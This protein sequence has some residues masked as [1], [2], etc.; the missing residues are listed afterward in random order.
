MGV[1][2]SAAPAPPE[3][4]RAQL[5]EELLAH[6]IELEMQ[7]E[8]LR[9]SQD[10]LR[11]EHD[12]YLDLYDLAPVGYLV[13]DD[14]GR[15]VEAN[16]R[17]AEVFGMS[18]ADLKEQP[19]GCLVADDDQDRLFLAQ[20]KVRAT[21]DRC[22]LEVRLQRRDPGGA[23]WVRCECVRTDAGAHPGALRV[24]LNDITE[25][26]RLQVQLALADRLA[27]LGALVASIGHEINNPLTYVLYDLET[28]TEEL[29]RV[30][31][32][33]RLAAGA[34][35]AP[36]SPPNG[37]V[38]VGLAELIERAQSALEGARRIRDLVKGVGAFSS[39]TDGRMAAVSLN[40]VLESTLVLI[41]RE[42]GLR[43]RL[44]TDLGDIPVVM[45]DPRQLCQVLLNLLLNAAQA[46]E[47]GDPDANVISVRTR[48]SGADVLVEV[49]D[50]GC[51]IPTDVRDR[52]FDPFFTTRD[53]GSGTGLGLSIC[54]RI[55][56]AHGGRISVESTVGRGSEF[57]VHLPR[58]PGEVCVAGADPGQ[59]RRSAAHGEG[60]DL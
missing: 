21:G 51:G 38:P 24:T 15:I 35:V 48:S 19:F 3:R 7:N 47:P 14:A 9:A 17:A 27:S 34:V 50:T 45:A 18:R 55:V 22:A 52:I 12:R 5:A 10:A 23:M 44:V 29:P 33:D 32:S 41:A 4:G 43:A 11:E 20:R 58:A 28:L 57:T 42:I 37:D 53:V 60:D 31:D 59:T 1:P 49:S 8:A 40:Q 13:L 39:T 30:M 54:A 36:G 46:I 6:Q 26:R 25:T 2:A 56:S 16:L